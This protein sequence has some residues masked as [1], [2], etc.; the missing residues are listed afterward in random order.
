M[1][2]EEALGYISTLGILHQRVVQIAKEKIWK[3]PSSSSQRLSLMAIIMT[4]VNHVLNEGSIHLICF[5]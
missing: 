4:S 2:S 3:G 1:N 5:I